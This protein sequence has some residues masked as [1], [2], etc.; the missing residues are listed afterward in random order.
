MPSHPCSSM[1]FVTV[2]KRDMSRLTAWVVSVRRRR[3]GD[4]PSAEFPIG[5]IEQVR[6]VRRWPVE[7][8]RRKELVVCIAVS[9]YAFLVSFMKACP[10]C[11]PDLDDMPHVFVVVWH[12]LL[13][14]VPLLS[15]YKPHFESDYFPSRFRKMFFVTRPSGS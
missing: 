3:T 4:E 11:E 8:E 14:A 13:L 12:L 10:S 7:G 2:W 1:V 9:F 15:V 5:H 6:I